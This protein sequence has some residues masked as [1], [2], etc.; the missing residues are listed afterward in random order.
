M[1]MSPVWASLIGI[2]HILKVGLLHPLV[3]GTKALGLVCLLV[4]LSLL[5]PG[6]E[7]VEGHTEVL[8]NLGFGLESLLHRQ[9]GLVFCLK[10]VVF[11]FGRHCQF[12][13]I[14]SN[15][16]HPLPVLLKYYTLCQLLKC[17]RNSDT[18]VSELHL[19]LSSIHIL[20]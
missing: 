6:E 11:A 13:G 16:F 3:L 12:W 7:G 5:E 14:A 4:V 15:V 2:I 18:K 8:I 9:D 20:H 19:Q 1:G 17:Q 10:S